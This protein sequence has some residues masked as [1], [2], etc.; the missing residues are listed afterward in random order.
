MR[1][2]E[3]SKKDKDMDAKRP[4]YLRYVN[5]ALLNDLMQKVADATGMGFAACDHTGRPVAG[6]I[7]YCEFCECVQTNEES[8]RSCEV[9]TAIGQI[10]SATIHKP[11]IYVYG[12]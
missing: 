6:A 1:D 7:G 4:A 2:V 8:Q 11:Y 5:I 3:L 9:S 10:Q 12:T